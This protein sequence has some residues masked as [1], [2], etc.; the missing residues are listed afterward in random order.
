MNNSRSVERAVRVMAEAKDKAK[1]SEDQIKWA[2]SVFEHRKKNT[3]IGTKIR[4][5][6][7]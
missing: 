1:K 5:L 2:R 7:V 4:Y 6:K 3:G